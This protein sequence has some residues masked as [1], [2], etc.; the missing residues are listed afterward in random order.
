MTR[1][2]RYR[3]GWLANPGV[4]GVEFSGAQA[5]P[6]AEWPVFGYTLGKVGAEQLMYAVDYL[7]EDSQVATA[8]LP[9]M[10]RGSLIGDGWN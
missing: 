1:P 10:R 7:C 4:A 3:A 8:R 2:S 9:R 6:R 5:S